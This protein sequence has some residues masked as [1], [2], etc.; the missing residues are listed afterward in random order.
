[1]VTIVCVPKGVDSLRNPRAFPCVRSSSFVFLSFCLGDALSIA[2]RPNYL[3][4]API[5]VTRPSLSRFL[6]KSMFLYLFNL[7]D[8]HPGIFYRFTLGL[9]M[10]KH[11]AFLQTHRVYTPSTDNAIGCIKQPL[12]SPALLCTQTTQRVHQSIRLLASLGGNPR[13]LLSSTSNDHADDVLQPPLHY[14]T[15]QLGW[16]DRQSHAPPKIQSSVQGAVDK[17][18]FGGTTL[19]RALAAACLRLF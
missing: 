17:L 7:E 18:A 4:G 11:L 14:N 19:R 5:F 12:A 3:V 2:N 10:V 16:P 8:V 15:A 13:S 1:V 9:L 6:G